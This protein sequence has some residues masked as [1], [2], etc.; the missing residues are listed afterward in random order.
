MGVILSVDVGTT[1]LKAGVVDATGK[2]L[3]LVRRETPV[4]RPE[5]DAA[6]MTSLSN[7][8]AAASAAAGVPANSP[9]ARSARGTSSSVP[10]RPSGA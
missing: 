7:R 6:A 5:P 1:T 4:L 3:S 9:T 8:A 10:L 2:I